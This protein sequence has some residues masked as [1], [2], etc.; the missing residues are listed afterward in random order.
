MVIE[1]AL[2][3]V[4]FGT[5]AIGFAAALLAW[6][7]RPEPGAI[8]LVLLLGGAVWWAAFLAFEVQ[9]DIVAQ[10][11]FWSNVQ[12]IGVVIIPVGWFLFAVEYTGRDQYARRSIVTAILV[13]PFVTAILALTDQYHALLHVDT[14]T[15][16]YADL[17]LLER[18]PGVWYWVIA[19]YTYVLGGLGILPLL[20]LIRS[21]SLPF[22]AQSLALLT[23]LLIPWATNIL[24]VADAT[25]IPGF[26]PTPIA[27]A[28]TGVA[29]LAAIDRFELMGINPT[30]NRRARRLIFDEM[31]DPAIVLDGNDHL[32]DMNDVAEAAFDRTR[33]A[34]VG[35]PVRS[36]L[37]ALAPA[38]DVSADH[39]LVTIDTR[40]GE[41]SFDVSAT[42]ITDVHDRRIGRVV[43]FHDVDDYLRQQQ[44]LEVLN[45]AFRH[46]IRTEA[47]IIMGYA[48]QLDD[49]TDETARIL[50]RHGREIADL[51]EKARE[52]ITI[53][54]RERVGVRPTSLSDL[55]D[56][57]ITSVRENYP[58]VSIELTPPSEE[59]TVATLL[60]PVVTNVVE[61]AAEH[62]PSADATVTISVDPDDDKVTIRIA[63]D[64]PGMD[65]SE[66][67][68][69]A[70][71][72]ETPLEHASGLGLWLIH[73][74][75]EIAGGTVRFAANEP[76][77]TIVSVE[78]PRLD[79]TVNGASDYQ[80]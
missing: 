24:F 71:G 12:W 59:C 4:L 41:T 65:E 16:E 31:S 48:D 58:E 79:E 28:I 9:T 73:W 60:G 26:D 25:P 44:R 63:D 14:T 64:G 22:R 74:G 45:R 17:A 78:V 19:A 57:A 62:N 36:V 75:T 66:C 49:D 20:E 67:A 55:L 23:G 7:K 27:F 53:F 10:K 37:P 70:E 34:T 11:I 33:K 42:D 13:V 8:P 46:N 6:R 2:T 30:P 50:K 56:G 29:F 76:T 69:I 5:V 68:V 47:Q 51:G 54:D 77:G 72:T 38:L 3:M 39:E 52:I 21:D 35:E 1:L 61:N 80:R 40:R 18:T 43:T 15:V 32:V